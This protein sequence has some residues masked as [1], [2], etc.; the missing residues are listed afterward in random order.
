VFNGNL[1]FIENTK[2]KKEERERQRRGSEMHK[3]E[4][5]DV[6]KFTSSMS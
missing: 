1:N 2:K 3:T 6:S 4:E 5:R